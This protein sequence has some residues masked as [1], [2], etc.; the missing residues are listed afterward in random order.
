MIIKALV[1]SIVVYSLLNT[2]LSVKEI[3]RTLLLPSVIIAMVGIYKGLEFFEEVNDFAPLEE[4]NIKITSSDD[5]DWNEMKYSKF[6]KKM[7]EPLGEG[8]SD[9]DMTG[10]AMLNTDKW[11]VP[12]KQPPRCIS[13]KECK[14]FF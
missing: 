3:N 8:I 10:E 4:S 9:W 5:E 12:L 13:Q 14:I 11:T 7:H 1:L 2:L 6:S